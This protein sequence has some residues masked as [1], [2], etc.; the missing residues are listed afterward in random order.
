MS[1]LVVAHLYGTPSEICFLESIKR[2]TAVFNNGDGQKVAIKRQYREYYIL[3]HN[4]NK[5]H[6]ILPLVTYILGNTVHKTLT[7]KIRKNRSNHLNKEVT[8]VILDV[9]LLIRGDLLHELLHLRLAAV[10]SEVALEVLDGLVVREDVAGAAAN[11]LHVVAGA[12]D[13]F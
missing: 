13:H 4:L 9:P 5:Y 12:H 2:H 7:C 11:L 1:L 6:L 10:V 8:T 3:Q